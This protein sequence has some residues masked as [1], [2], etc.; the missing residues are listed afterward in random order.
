MK[1]KEKLIP[2]YFF[3]DRGYDIPIRQILDIHNLADKIGYSKYGEVFHF[4]WGEDNLKDYLIE[5]DLIEFKGRGPLSNWDDYT[6]KDK[7]EFLKCMRNFWDLYNVM[8]KKQLGRERR[9]G[10]LLNK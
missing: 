2:A 10:K 7:D 9:L 1:L 4:D 6:F 8:D 3:T 5:L